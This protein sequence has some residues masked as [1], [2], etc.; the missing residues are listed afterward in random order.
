[1]YTAAYAKLETVLKKLP[2]PNGKFQK[3]QPS[4]KLEITDDLDKVITLLSIA[5]SWCEDACLLKP[6]VEGIAQQL[7]ITLTIEAIFNA[8]DALKNSTTAETIRLAAEAM[9]LVS[10]PAML[11]SKY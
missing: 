2:P 6:K 3:L 10:L 9:T 11:V 1:M 4:F 7:G 5:Q 8:N